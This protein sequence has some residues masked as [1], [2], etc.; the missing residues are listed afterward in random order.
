MTR[1]D[2]LPVCSNCGTVLW[3][4][5][6]DVDTE[7]VAVGCCDEEVAFT[8]QKGVI[9]SKCPTCKEPF[10]QIT[11]PIKL[12]FTTPEKPETCYILKKEAEN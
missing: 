3:N 8:H 2:F 7:E 1:I 5:T 12:P 10:E 11:I 4:Q 9:P 6:I